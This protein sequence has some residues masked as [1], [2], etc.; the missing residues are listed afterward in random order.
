MSRNDVIA[1][2]LADNGWAKSKPESLDADFSS[3]RFIRLH[4]DDNDRTAILMDAE[5]D[6][7]NE[8]FTVLAWL[9]R[10]MNLSAPEIYAERKDLGLVLMEDFGEGNVGK[11]IDN[12]LF[13]RD[14]CY[15]RC[16]TVLAH[17]HQNFTATTVRDLK[18]PVYNAALFTKQTEKFLDSYVPH[19]FSRSVSDDERKA[20]RAAWMEV[21]KP[22]DSMP[23]T[24]ML[25]DFMPDNVMD[26]PDRKS[27]RS[28]G[29]VDFQDA[30]VGP[31]AYDLASFCEVVRRDAGDIFLKRVL[32]DYH[33]RMKPPYTF[34][35]LTY[36]GNVMAL[37]R[38]MRILG[39]L[40][41]IA[42]KTPDSPKL[43]YLPRVRDYVK[44]LIQNE[45]VRP[46]L[47]WLADAGIKFD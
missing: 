43:A 37:Q 11:L 6:P 18:L 46:V 32:T 21:L 28:F 5:G 35:A 8:V 12:G 47:A 40:G 17:L 22:L 19:S 29:L 42:Q 1:A 41:G 10:G 13:S 25:R 9:L 44:Y 31:V 3:R 24:L 16:S 26:L 4:H 36:A 39:I 45:H 30:G 20:F 23:Q 15:N 34:D 14:E 38:H 2:F 7:K 33:Q 27:W